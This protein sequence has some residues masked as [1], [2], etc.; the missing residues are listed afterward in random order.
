LGAGLLL[1]LV[2]AVFA[3]QLGGQSSPAAAQPV[4][5]SRPDRIPL[6]DIERVS[7]AD[8]YAA[9]EQGQAVFLDVRFAESYA[10]GHIP[11]AVLIPEPEVP[12]RLG[13][14]DP[15]QWIITYCT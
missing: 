4:V 8:S 12:D 1:I 14:L 2:A 11:G 6:P 5:V 13:E 10:A 15:N 7:L 3:I 9:F